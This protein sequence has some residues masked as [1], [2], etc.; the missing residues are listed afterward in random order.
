VF[1]DEKSE[2]RDFHPWRKLT[3]SGIHRILML[4]NPSSMKTSM[5]S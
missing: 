4:A 5:M 3:S 2:C 1:V